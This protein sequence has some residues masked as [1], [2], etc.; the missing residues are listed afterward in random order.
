MGKH[1]RDVDLKFS[2]GSRL[3]ETECSFVVVNMTIIIED[4]KRGG[5]DEEEPG[6][7]QAPSLVAKVQRA[8]QSEGA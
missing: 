3:A 5:N 4:D 1:I 7:E 8:P 2:R 6:E